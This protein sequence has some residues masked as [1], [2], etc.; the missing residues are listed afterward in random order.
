MAHGRAHPP[1]FSRKGSPHSPFLFQYLPE[2]PDG[3]K[4]LF[5]VSTSP[6]SHTGEVW[7]RD[8]K[9]GEERRLSLY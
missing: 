2:S 3:S 6:D 5:F 9:T 1:R 7:I 8:R 4:V